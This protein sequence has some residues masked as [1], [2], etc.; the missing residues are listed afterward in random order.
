MNLV[1]QE[2]EK[3]I[4]S[5]EE[6]R[7]IPEIAMMCFAEATGAIQIALYGKLITRDEYRKYHTQAYISYINT[8]H[9]GS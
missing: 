3:K 7:P 2:I 1:K 8:D 9:F 6:N 4:Q 5:I